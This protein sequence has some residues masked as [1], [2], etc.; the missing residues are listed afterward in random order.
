[1]AMADFL[2]EKH[3]LG[4]HTEL[5]VDAMVDLIECGAV[6]NHKRVL[7]NGK[8]TG[9][10]LVGTDKIYRFSHHNPLVELHPVDYTND[11]NM[12][13]NNNKMI[14]VNATL[15]V[16]LF[17]QCV[18][19]SFGY[20]KLQRFRRPAGFHPRCSKIPGWQ[21]YFGTSLNCQSRFHLPYRP[22]SQQRSCGYRTSQR[23]RLYSY[24]IWSYK[25][26]SQKSA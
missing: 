17:G 11:A 3:D 13:A 19:E 25:T 10:A 15:E 5:V 26:A 14:A 12:I 4:I 18:S 21:S 1:M 22:L 6:N 9:T 23:Y 2:K 20:I 7:H 24:R 8:I 16:D